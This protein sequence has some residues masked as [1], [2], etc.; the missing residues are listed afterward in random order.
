MLPVCF[1]FE[2]RK[3][4]S[5]VSARGCLDGLL[6]RRGSR[7]APHDGGLELIH[8]VHERCE[9]S[10][11]SLCRREVKRALVPIHLDQVGTVERGSGVRVNKIVRDTWAGTG[12]S[13]RCD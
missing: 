11:F 3:Q 1:L 2:I 13:V 4:Q 10:L 12:T 8:E 5:A 7:A 9:H 6:E